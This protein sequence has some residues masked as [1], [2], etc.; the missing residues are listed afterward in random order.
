MTGDPYCSSHGTGEAVKE[1][2]L[3]GPDKGLAN[4]FVYVKEGVEGSYPA[5]SEPVVLDQKGCTYHPRV[6]G[7]IVDNLEILNND[8]TTHNVRAK[9]VSNPCRPGRAGKD[10]PCGEAL[11]EPRGDRQHQMQCTTARCRRLWVVSHPFFSVTGENGNFSIEN[12][13]PGT[14]TMEPDSAKLGRAE[15]RRSPSTVMK[16]SPPPSPAR[17]LR[18]HR[19]RKSSRFAFW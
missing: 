10:A 9:C 3:V 7:I 11:R 16:S 6:F 19:G 17:G 14:Y 8:E 4:V 18:Q 1:E 13:P 15:L 2:V 12:L 5:P